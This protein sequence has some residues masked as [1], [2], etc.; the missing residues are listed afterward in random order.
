MKPILR[1]G[2]LFATNSP[3][4]LGKCIRA[5][6]WIWAWDREATYNHAGIIVSAAGL[7]LESLLTFRLSNLEA[8]RGRKILIVRHKEMTGERCAAGLAAVKGDVGHIY[9]VYRLAL[10]LIPPLAKLKLF[11]GGVCSEQ[12]AKFLKAA[13][14]CNVVYGVTPD[15][16]ADLWRESKSMDIIF[17]GVW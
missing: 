1:A 13:G 17:E 8:Y 5:V 11:G 12:T 4:L 9:P 2:D 7:T 10:F 6:Q 16:L 14:F 15:N 3:N